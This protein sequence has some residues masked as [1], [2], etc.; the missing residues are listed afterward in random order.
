MH[1]QMLNEINGN[2]IYKESWGLR[3]L[4][5]PIKKIKFYEFMNIELPKQ[6]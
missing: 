3:N 6:Y 2:I 4:A 1:E 5:Y